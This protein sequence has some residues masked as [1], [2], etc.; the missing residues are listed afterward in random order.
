MEILSLYNYKESEG[1]VIVMLAMFKVLFFF[2]ADKWP[3]GIISVIIYN[4]TERWA[5]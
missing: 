3:L 4:L 1:V 5:I 2:M